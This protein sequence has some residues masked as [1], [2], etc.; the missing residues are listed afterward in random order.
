MLACG[1]I[2]QAKDLPKDL[3]LVEDLRSRADALVLR[4]GSAIIAPD[5]SVLAGPVL[6][7]EKILIA[8]LDFS[9]ITKENLTLDVTG[10]YARPDIFDLRLR[11]AK[12]SHP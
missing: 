1:A 4:G 2:L 9:A 8:D 12:S 6:D 11:A 3:N 10:H 7:E 5:G